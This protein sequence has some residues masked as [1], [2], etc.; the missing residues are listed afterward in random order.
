VAGETTD[1]W[2]SRPLLNKLDN[3]FNLKG[4]AMVR[5]M[6]STTLLLSV[7]TPVICEAGPSPLEL[8]K[9]FSETQDKLSASF[10]SKAESTS[11]WT[12]L[13]PLRPE[14]K[15]GGQYQS[16]RKIE[17]RSDGSRFYTWTKNWGNNPGKAPRTEEQANCVFTL[18]D[19]DSRYQYMCA[20]DSGRD[21]G[22]LI[23]KNKKQV[24]VDPLR[25]I[26]LSD[27]GPVRGFFYGGRPDDRIDTEL[28]QADRILVQPAME[29]VGDAQCYVINARAKGCDYKIW[30]DPEHDYN[31]ARA[32]VKRPWYSAQPPEY[33]RGRSVKGAIKGSSET[34]VE[35]IRFRQIDGIWVPVECD[36]SLNTKATQGG[37]VSS[38]YHYKVTEYQL[39]P[40]HEALGSFK[41]D[42]VRNGAQVRLSGVE[43]IT[44]TW[45]DGELIPNVDEA[46][47]D[48]LDNIAQEIMAEAKEDPGPAPPGTLS[49]SD[50]LSRYRVSQEKISSLIAKAQSTIEKN[51]PNQQT[52]S[53]FRSDGDRVCHR[54]TSW[55]N[56]TETK[57]NPGYGSFLWDGQSLITYHTY[58]NIG[59]AHVFISKDKSGK[60]S[61]VSNEYKGAPLLGYCPGDYKRIDLILVGADDI[62]LREKTEPIG[63]SKCY[64]ID[65]QTKCGKYGVWI[66]PDHGY[67]IAKI[68]VQRKKGD[69]VGDQ[70]TAKTD[71][72]FTLYNVRFEQID[73]IWV[74]MEAEMKQTDDSQSKT[75]KC[76]HKR[77]EV[78]LNPDH[79]ALKSFVADDIPDGTNVDFSDDKTKYIWQDGKPA[80]QAKKSNE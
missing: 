28:R 41:P 6:L 46:A 21:K 24:T 47:V 23:L 14:I 30:I 80:A 65:A 45:R 25:S 69:L 3:G 75:V 52:S 58:P 1:R 64:V 44:Y 55:D 54:A 57:E 42:F 66:D 16:Y 50:L 49:V 36:Y 51:G 35:N 11:T 70:A 77:T 59:T 74:P 37:Y 22:S 34:V 4:D 43:G 20:P 72:S 12:A 40:D 79:E 38:R 5:R 32:I 31:I 8:L 71:M 9:R 56:V 78:I 13:E 61:I 73:K 26:N 76:H 27:G 53:E 18:W 48:Q 39:N 63:E 17:L 62:S 15:P 67:N 7:I 60:E 10:I 2:S 68:E 33:Y 19:G 29:D